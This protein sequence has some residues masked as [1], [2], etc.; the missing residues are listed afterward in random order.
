MPNYLVEVYRG[1][2]RRMELARAGGR[3][4]AAAEA[5][6]RQGSPVRFV[7]FISVPGDEMCFYLYEAASP[8][9]IDEGTRATAIPV[10]RV[11]EAEWFGW[12]E[13]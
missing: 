6:T 1:T 3:A 12:D 8:V 11:V 2:L 10:E 7:G 13:R 4:R 9:T 5:L